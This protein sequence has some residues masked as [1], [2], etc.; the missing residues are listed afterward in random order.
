[1]MY[2]NAYRKFRTYESNLVAHT[3]KPS[4]ASTAKGAVRW[5]EIRGGASAP[6]VFQ[7]GTFQDNSSTANSYWLPSMGQDKRGDIVLGFSVSGTKTDP[8]MWYT[9][10]VPSDALG[11]MESANIVVT[12]TGV[13]RATFNRWGDY[14]TVSIDPADDCTF[15][16]TNE[17]IK[18]TGSFNWSTRITS[19]KFPG[20]K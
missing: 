9:G 14:A 4:S 13:Q 8:S 1:M 12:G 2:R 6:A 10:R 7:Q 5:Y 11:T 18:T 20:C 3:V 15:W 17:Y 16:Y 19:F